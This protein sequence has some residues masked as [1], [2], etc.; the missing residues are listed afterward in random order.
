MGNRK[1]QQGTL[2]C[3]GFQVPGVWECNL[4]ALEGAR[5]KTGDGLLVE[6]M[7]GKDVNSMWEVLCALEGRPDSE[8]ELQTIRQGVATRVESRH[9][10]GAMEECLP[11]EEVSWQKYIQRTRQGRRMGGPP[12]VEAW[13]VEGGCRVAVYRDSK[14]GEGYRKL[15]E[16][17]DGTLLDAGILWT[18]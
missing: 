16:Y 17:G 11:R 15:V 5:E 4:P 2:E 9:N 13:A 1:R 12:E 18:S 7:Y 8:E 6:H 14:S 10:L 3:F